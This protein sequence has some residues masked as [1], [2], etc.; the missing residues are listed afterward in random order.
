MQTAYDQNHVVRHRLRS[1]YCWV[2]GRDAGATSLHFNAIDTEQA[3]KLAAKYFRVN[4]VRVMSRE[5]K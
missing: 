4:E 1:F 2:A 5:L 3:E